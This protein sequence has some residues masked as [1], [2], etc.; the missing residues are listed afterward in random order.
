MVIKCDTVYISDLGLQFILL[1]QVTWLVTNYLQKEG[2]KKKK[3]REE[4]VFKYQ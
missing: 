1:I 2:K 4:K 3:D